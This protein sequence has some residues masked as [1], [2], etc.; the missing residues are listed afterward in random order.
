MDVLFLGANN[1][2]MEIYDW[3][4]DRETVSVLGMITRG[5]QLDL[6]ADQQPDILVA[7]GFRDIVP[8]EILDI[9]PEGCVNLHPGLLPHARGMNPNVWS[10]VDNLPAGAT[11]HYMDEDIDTG[12]II[13]R[14][15]VPTS[16]EDTGKDV[17]ER[18]ETAAFELFT[19]SWPGIEHGEASAQQQTDADATY[20]TKS[21]FDDLC[22]ITP[23]KQ[24]EARELLDILR[25]LTFPPFDNAFVEVEGERYYIDI[26]ITHESA[27]SDGEAYGTLDSYGES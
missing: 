14:K 9:P 11:L 10:I 15:R 18:I 22:R 12:Q 27:V 2:G 26:D 17:Y 7:S 23:E 6:V 16:F 19:E 21:D 3:L 8:P 13:A 25:A 4:C 24:Y 5:K 1:I 20:H